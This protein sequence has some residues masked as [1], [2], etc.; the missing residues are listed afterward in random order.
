[1]S[2]QVG[3]IVVDGVDNLLTD[4]ADTDGAPGVCQVLHKVLPHRTSLLPSLFGLFGLLQ[5]AFNLS[6]LVLLRQLGLGDAVVNHQMVH[7]IG[8]VVLV[9]DHALPTNMTG[10]Q[11]LISWVFREMIPNNAFLGSDLLRR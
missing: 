7:H 11:R 10:T 5:L 2:Y 3:C 1:M 9:G 6:L 8:R 4:L